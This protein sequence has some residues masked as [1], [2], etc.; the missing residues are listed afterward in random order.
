MSTR[1]ADLTEQCA[2]GKH[3]RVRPSDFAAIW[4][5]RSGPSVGRSA[6]EVAR[7]FIDG[8]G[9]KHTAGNVPYHYLGTAERIEQMLPLD[10]RGAHAK[11]F[12]NA[13]GIGFA[14]VGDFRHRAPA[15][16]QWRRA[17][18]LC[19]DLVPALV[20]LPL[21]MINMVP[22]WL[23]YG[24]PIYGHGEVS[25]AFARGSGKEQPNGPAACPGKHWSM[26]EFRADVQSELARRT[27]ARLKKL[28]HR[29]A[30]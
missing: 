24:P 11:A 3:K 20:P 2:D 19:A 21:F 12:G 7:F 28:G 18:M 17:V 6:P 26:S 14:Q 15:P 4:I 9:A 23:R 16:A 10:E 1:V 29:L 22:P 13:A 8:P 25:S 30:L 5:H 27:A